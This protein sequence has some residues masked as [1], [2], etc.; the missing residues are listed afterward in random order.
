LRFINGVL[1][2][3]LSDAAKQQGNGS[4]LYAGVMV[5]GNLNNHVDNFT[6]RT[7]P[8]KPTSLEIV[9]GTPQS[10]VKGTKLASPFVVRLADENGSGVAN[11]LIKFTVTQGGGTLDKQQ[12][13]D[14][15][16]RLEAESGVIAAPMTALNDPQAS[17]GKF[18]LVPLGTP[19]GAAGSATYSFEIKSPGN[20]VIWG[21]KI[22]A[23]GDEDSFFIIV[24]GGREITWHLDQS[25]VWAWDRVSDGATGPDPAVFTLAAGTHTLVVKQRETNVKLDKILITSNLSYVPSGKEEVQG[26]FTD[27]EGKTQAYLTLGPTTGTNTVTASYL[28]LPSVTFTAT[29]LPGPPDKIEKVS[30][31][32]LKAMPGQLCPSPLW[33][34]L[35][36]AQIRYQTIR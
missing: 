21:R 20:Y 14:G 35:R 24:D 8:G 1:D 33:F 27:A 12:T 22:A 29:A 6:I 5:T 18:I 2:G 9:S 30:G 31:D 15:N 34:V 11:A 17:G 26:Y 19:E 23:T 4:A 25:E 3:I 32:S 36:R 7:V 10:G 13:N 28:S 16:I